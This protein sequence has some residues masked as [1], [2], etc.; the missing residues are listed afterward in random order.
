VLAEIAVKLQ[1][2]NTYIMLSVLCKRNR[3]R[4]MIRGTEAA[5]WHSRSTKSR[6]LVHSTQP[7]R[8][9]P[10]GVMFSCK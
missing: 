2:L 7:I 10:L 8:M 5:T 4:A 6:C 9:Y 1:S 3:K